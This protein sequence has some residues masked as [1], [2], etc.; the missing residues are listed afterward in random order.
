MKLKTSWKDWILKKVR[1]IID[2]QNTNYML[3]GV[4]SDKISIY[5]QMLRCFGKNYLKLFI[6]ENPIRFSLKLNGI[7]LLRMSEFH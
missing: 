2:A 1:R 3:F 5:Q 4:F 7:L 6:R